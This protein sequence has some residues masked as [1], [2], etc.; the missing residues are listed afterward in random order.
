MK[1]DF[2]KLD[3]NPAD[4]YTGVLYQQGRVFVDTDGTS[5]TLIENHL[6][7]ILAQD[8]IGPNV[9]AVPAAQP[10]SFKVVQ[11]Q[12]TTTDVTV[13]LKAGHLWADG[14][15][16]A[17]V[18]TTDV[19]LKATYLGPPIETPQPAPSGITASTR[20]AVILEVWEDAFNA[21]QDPA[22]L[23]EPA[24]GGVDTTE[25]V[26]ASY[27]LKLLRLAAGE[28]CNNI[29]GRLADNFN[30]KGHLTVTPAASMTITGDCPIDAGG[31]YSGFEHFL[32]RVEIADPDSGGNAR[33]KWSQFNGGL[34][35]RGEFAS[36]GGTTGT[37]TI[38][39]NNQMIN[40]CG[41]TSFYL[42]ALKYDAAFGHWRVVFSANATLPQDDT[43]SLTGI[44]GTW[45]ATAPS[46]AFFRLWNGISLVSAFPIPGGGATAN[47]LKDGIQLAFDAPASGKYT[48]GDYWTFPVRAAG[49]GVDAAWIAANWPNSAPPQGVHYHRVPLAVLS[50]SGV[51]PVT[52][53][54]AADQIED[55]RRVFD[56]LTDL[57]GCCL[58]V[59]PGDDIHRALKKIFDA[60]GGCLCLLPGDHV[61]T[62][63]I[64]LTGRDSIRI[65]GF[66]PATRLLISSQIETP[67]PFILT[68]AHDIS[69]ESFVVIN[70]SLLPLWRCSN[71]VRLRVE[72]VFA[73]T[74]LAG[75][76]QTVFALQG[77]CHGWRLVDNVFVAPLGLAG[78]L[79]ASSLILDN[80][81]IGA[82]RGIDLVYAQELQVERNDFLG[83]HP[84]LVKDLDTLLGGMATGATTLS[85][86]QA[87]SHGILGA[88]NAAVAPG[89]IGIEINGAFDVDIID[90]EFYGS[91]GL[92]LEWTENCLIQRNR[93]RTLVVASACGIAHGLR[94]N[95]NRVGVAAGDEKLQTPIACETGL[96]LL[97]D[98][99]ECR[100]ADNVFA[101]VKQGVAFQSDFGGKKMVARDFSANLFMM[102]KTTDAGAQKLLDEAEARSK[103]TSDKSLLLASSFFKVGTSQRVVIEGNQ[104]HASETGIEWSGTTQVFDFRIAGNAF[105]GCQDVAIQ[106]EP[107]ARI[108]LLAEPVDTRV[109]LIENNRFEIFSGAVRATIGAVRVEKNDIR[110]DAPAFKVVPPKEILGVAAD[111]IYNSPP[112]AQATKSDDIPLVLM[113][114]TEAKSAAESNPEAINAP[115][116]AK[117]A[118]DK[119]LNTYK[120]KK[121]DAV[122]DKVFV[123]KTLAD[124][125]ANAYLGLL[126]NALFPKWTFNSEGFVINLAGIQNRVLNNRLYG[127]N[128]QRPGG[129]LFNA[130]SGEVRNNEIVVPGTAV[131]LNGKLS[132]ASGYQGGEVVGNSL[133][134]LGV[135]GSKTAVYALAIPSLSAGN[136]AI[137]NNI[138]KG[139]VMIG[140][141]PLSAQGFNNN[142]VFTFPGVLTFYNAMKLEPATYA[143]SSLIKLFPNKGGHF[144]VFKPPG[145]IFPIW[146]T[147]P[148]AS[149]PIV[150]FCQNRVI[151]GWVG[152]FQALSGAYWSVATLKSQAAQALIANIGNN[153]I[154]YGGSAVGSELIVSG[155]YSQAA[156]KYR[157]GNRVQ[158][159]AN[160][161]A[162]VSF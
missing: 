59:K 102:S 91:V 157:V 114:S 112:M 147:D 10:D 92:Y 66:G 3:F 107:E 138:F 68:N 28:D 87:L 111:H 4:N 160:I 18:S 17:L 123:M 70:Q 11:A 149:R 116:F 153:V 61:L 51:P 48:P 46:T 135:P 33:F 30:N 141:D 32:Y 140:G 119:I 9:A 54:A 121:G 65:S 50:W 7:T 55:C 2:S 44:G 97:A 60:G 108:L 73:V 64:D 124:I 101:N 105:I 37:V 128:T 122:A 35:G 130:V 151:Q 137:N 85:S 57:R 42:E 24:L 8:A 38:K 154:D 158:A 125:G 100:I 12:A 1:G 132:L 13:T 19:N 90:N 56:P 106:I 109:R 31:G 95:E 22:H 26:K 79:L 27:A 126:G 148:N 134:A 6:R 67:A 52:I 88:T 14:I 98:V 16:L 120:A 89:Y 159:V 129:V 86:G 40:H 145:I 36:T 146:L 62:Q 131:L 117:D 96:V 99:V 110:V 74:P 81:W 136:L 76:N 103:E 156:L 29:A 71:T 113:M 94:F 104:F 84:D 77:S 45:P 15:P 41:L 83:I 82:R 142:N 144:G 78:R 20:D 69:F 80:V 127:K 150:Q 21:F 162:A 34:V 161:P 152:I 155:N 72:S 25:R 58:E 63:P 49:A 75:T 115:G 53:T 47:P 93:F 139:S 39:A 133:V 118:G 23:I 5:E 143:I 43:L